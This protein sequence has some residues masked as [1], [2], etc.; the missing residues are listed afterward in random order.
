MIDSL[1]LPRRYLIPFDPRDLPHHFTDV[2]VIG[3]GLAGLR[4]GARGRRAGPGPGRH[5]GRGP[6]EQQRLRPG[7]DR[8]R[9]ST[10]RTTSTTTSPT[11]SPPAR[12]SATPRSSRWSS[13]RRPARIGELIDWGTHFDQ[14]DGHVALGREGGHSHARIVH[15]L[16]DATGREVMRAVIEQVRAPRQHPDL[17]EQLHDRPADP[18]G[19]LPGRPR[20]GPP[21]RPL[22][23]LGP[24]DRPGHRRRRPALPRV[25][26][27]ADRH[28]RRPRRWPTAPGPSCATWSSCSSTRPSSTS[29]ARPGTC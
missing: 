29:P 18:R 15:A 10:P 27:P 14:V 9:S 5:Q 21:P 24:G 23:D 28:R 17:A 22:A 16:G 6:R 1:D 26:Q 4:A 20:L 7:R 2:L 3:G 13:A 12:G 8:R 19:P 25:D 11:R